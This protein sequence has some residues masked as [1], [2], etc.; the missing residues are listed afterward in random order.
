MLFSQRYLRAIN[1]GRI[2]V[3]IHPDA[4]KKIWAWLLKNNHS[5]G[6]Q[7]DPNDNWISNS[8]ILEEAEDELL[9]EHGWDE[10][11]GSPKPANGEY[12]VGAKY[13]ALHGDGQFV[14][15]IL[16]LA[17][18]W[19]DTKGKETFRNKINQ[20]F[21]LHDCPWRFSDGEFFKLDSDFVGARLAVDAH[22][23]LTANNFTGAADEYA[24]SRQEFASG[25]IKDAILYA[26][27]SFES[28][29]KIFTGLEHA[30]ADRLLKDMLG[31]GYF[32]DLPESIRLGFLD[33]VLKS[34]PFLRN[35]LGGH[36]QGPNVIEVP[37]VY[38]ELSIQLAAAFHNFLISKHL[39]RSTPKEVVTQK[40]SR[41]MDDEIPF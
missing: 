1:N 12:F 8:S 17:S 20:I 25:D 22:D 4:R 36:G 2:Q 18:N 21:E 9:T 6:V 30:N 38:G 33:Q 34:L 10:I 35:K 16:E 14:F 27:K 13:L 3:D 5:R 39:Q 32:D 31:K 37:P 24:K 15:D 19:M 23:A 28:I 26:G 7:R 11:P 41:D 40:S 29:L